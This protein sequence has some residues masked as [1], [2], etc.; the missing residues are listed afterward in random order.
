MQNNDCVRFEEGEIKYI[1]QAILL[2]PRIPQQSEPRICNER[3]AL[4]AFSFVFFLPASPFSYPFPYEYLCD[5]F[6]GT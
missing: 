5:I 6:L 1:L 2:N 3:V 4:Q